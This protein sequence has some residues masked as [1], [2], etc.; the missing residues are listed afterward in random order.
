MDEQTSSSKNSMTPIIVA[1]IVIFVIVIA[2]G[3]F[4]LN[5]RRAAQKNTTQ[6]SA[7]PTQTLIQ[8]QNSPTPSAATQRNSATGSGMMQKQNVIEVTA[9]NF[10]YNPKSITVPVNQP[11]TI[12]FKSIGGTHDFYLDEFNVK[13][14]PVSSGSSETITFTPTKKGTFQ[15]YCNIGNHRKMGMVGTLI[16]Q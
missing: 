2:G 11:V 15:Y 4:V 6:V 9:Q 1:A 13:S 3:Y 12:N 14:K 10:S 8:N 16:V 5:N 7:S